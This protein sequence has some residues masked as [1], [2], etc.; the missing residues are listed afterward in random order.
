MACKSEP[1]A[2]VTG[3]DGAIL[4]RLRKDPRTWYFI[5][6]EMS[7]NPGFVTVNLDG[8]L[9]QMAASGA[10]G[11]FSNL[12]GPTVA[13]L[14]IE[15]LRARR[16][17]LMPLIRD[18]DWKVPGGIGILSGRL[19]IDTTDQIS[20]RLAQFASAETASMAACMADVDIGKQLVPPS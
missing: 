7:W 3:A 5:G 8:V 17:R 16:D 6:Q 10:N 12:L 18:N 13:R 20:D 4:Q 1:C 2:P 11:L 14:D 19:G 15:K 9:D